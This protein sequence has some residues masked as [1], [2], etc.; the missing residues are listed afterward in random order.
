[1]SVKSIGYK[2]AK[3]VSGTYTTP[4]LTVNRAGQIT[5]IQSQVIDPDDTQEAA[6]ETLVETMADVDTALATVT[7]SL[8]NLTK[9]QGLDVN[10]SLYVQLQ[11]KY[12]ELNSQFETLI[13]GNTSNLIGWTLDQANFQNRLVGDTSQY[14]ALNAENSIN[15]D[16]GFYNI[17]F[18][19]LAVV[20][21]PSTK[22]SDFFFRVSDTTGTIKGPCQA[23][24]YG[25]WNNGDNTY[26]AFNG[27]MC[28]NM[29][30]QAHVDLLVP[31]TLGGATI[32]YT[33]IANWEIGSFTS[34]P[35][36]GDYSGLPAITVPAAPNAIVITAL[37][38][39]F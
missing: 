6:Y 10:Y 14:R 7:T 32:I 26:V 16:T 15:L 19:F 2:S 4:K 29:N 25:S 11:E 18:N 24:C 28:F 13:P 31:N 9:Y 3:V 1:M 37:D 35:S 21:T 38:F 27:S 20:A 17:D 23:F 8:A 22:Q 34:F 33:G 12:D 36:S 5:E 39:A 30:S